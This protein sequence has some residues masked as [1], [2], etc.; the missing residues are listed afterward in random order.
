MATKKTWLVEQW[1]KIAEDTVVPIRATVEAT[2]RKKAQEGAGAA[3]REAA[4]TMAERH[5]AEP[6]EPDGNATV[7]YAIG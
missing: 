2:T 5:G 4:A 3:C 6:G 7:L 1:W